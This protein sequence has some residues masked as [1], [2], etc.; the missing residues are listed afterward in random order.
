[1][2]RNSPGRGVDVASPCSALPNGS[3]S[4]KGRLDEEETLFL[5][6]TR[7]AS[8]K[9]RELVLAASWRAKV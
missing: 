7:L 1:M 3:S 4:L 6:D 2:V 8:S 5:P 9:R